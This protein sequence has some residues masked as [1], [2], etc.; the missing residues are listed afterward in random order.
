MSRYSGYN[1]VDD[2]DIDDEAE[3]LRS[4]TLPSSEDG[5]DGRVQQGGKRERLRSVLLPAIQS[6]V[7]A[8]GGFEDVVPEFDDEHTV[9]AYRLGDEALGC[10]KDLKRFWKLDD[11]DEERTIARI[12]FEA[13]LLK[14]DLVHIVN[15]AGKPGASTRQEKAALAS[16]EP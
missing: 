15:A 10:L 4:E 14:N 11:T 7:T 8:L 16:G 3:E 13:G 12:F 6:R 5:E 2:E 1:H 9:K